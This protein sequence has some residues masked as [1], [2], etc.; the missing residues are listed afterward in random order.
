MQWNDDMLEYI[1]VSGDT[2][3]LM[4]CVNHDWRRAVDVYIAADLSRMTLSRLKMFR[5]D[6]TAAPQYV[7]RLT[8]RSIARQYDITGEEPRYL[9]GMCSRKLHNIASC[10]CHLAQWPQ[11]TT[12]AQHRTWRDYNITLLSWAV[13]IIA[14]MAAHVYFP[15]SLAVVTL[16]FWFIYVCALVTRNGTLSTRRWRW[17]NPTFVQT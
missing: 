11:D 1:A 7:R 10:D 16:C 13:T 15:R 8:I 3:L 9:C 5:I 4:R 6:A 14:T 2:L 17:V 12:T